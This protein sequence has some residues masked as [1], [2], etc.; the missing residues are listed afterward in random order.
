MIGRCKTLNFF[1][2]LKSLKI[3]KSPTTLKLLKSLRLFVAI[4]PLVFL[5]GGCIGSGWFVPYAVQPSYWK[6]QKLADIQDYRGYDYRPEKEETHNT[7]LSYFGYKNLDELFLVEPRIYQDEKG[8][9]FKSY[10]LTKEYNNR[11]TIHLDIDF[12]PTKEHKKPKREDIRWLT[13]GIIWYNNRNY[14]VMKPCTG[15]YCGIGIV[16]DDEYFQ[17]KKFKDDD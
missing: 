8:I 12:F 15:F 16:R 17:T 7:M 10:F 14:F 1:K 9:I 11:I 2:S 13:W 3:F 5:F 4:T 6:A